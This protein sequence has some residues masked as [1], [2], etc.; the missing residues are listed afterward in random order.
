MK[1][2]LPN[3]IWTVFFILVWILL[4]AF[5][6]RTD[7]SEPE[8]KFRFGIG[9]DVIVEQGKDVDA[10]VAIGGNL[11]VYG[12]V[13]K[14]A[15]SIGGSVYLAPFS[16][17]DGDVTAV[18]GHVEQQDGAVVGGKISAIDTGSITSLLSSFSRGIDILPEI[19]WGIGWISSIGFIVL[20][21]VVVAVMPSIVGSVSFSIEHNTVRTLLL[22]ILGS[23]VVFPVVIMLLV[24]IVGIVLIPLEI[25]LVGSAMILGY[26]AVSQLIGKR[27]TFAM[28]RP[29]QPIL[30]E[31][32]LGLAVLFL[33]GFVP[34]FGF[35]VKGVV[36]LLGL[37]GVI[38]AIFL[39][40]ARR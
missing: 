13:R 10:A 1:T 39:R 17:V 27:V 36:V 19:G 32:S 29:H 8:G 25:M 24:S 34:F 31:T 11:E 4:A 30:L 35:V 22:G 2:R 16:I 6:P 7:K 3:V 37:G 26:I 20:A 40:W 38:D 21:L 33:A 23:I 14:D 15:V 28:K 9:H 18:G 5:I 12:H